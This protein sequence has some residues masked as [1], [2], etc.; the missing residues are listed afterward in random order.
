[1]RDA[2]LQPVLCLAQGV[3]GTCLYRCQKGIGGIRTIFD[4]C[5]ILL[6]ETRI[7]FTYKKTTEVPCEAD[8]E[9]QLRFAEELTGILSTK[10]E[11][12]VIYYADGVHPAHNSRSTSVWIRKVSS[13]PSQP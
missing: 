7:G 9:E 13:F 4:A 12:A 10:D 2:R 11:K 3:E 1:M 5:P 8:F 6:K